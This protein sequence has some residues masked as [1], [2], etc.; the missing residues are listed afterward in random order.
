MVNISYLLFLYVCFNGIGAIPIITGLASQ[1]VDNYDNVLAVPANPRFPGGRPKPEATTF[2]PTEDNDRNDNQTYG[3]GGEEGYEDVVNEKHVLPNTNLCRTEYETIYEIEDVETKEEKCITVSERKCET[4]F[5]SKC[6]PYLENVCQTV[7][8]NKCDTE[9]NQECQQLFREEEESY[10][11]DKCETKTVRKCE[12]YWKMVSNNRKVWEEN[13]DKC[14]D[15]LQTECLPVTN[16]RVNKLPYQECI[17]VPVQKCTQVEDNVCNDV[18][19]ERC[20]QE[21]YEECRNVPREECKIE[22]KLIPQQISRQIQIRV[23]DDNER[24]IGPEYDDYEEDNPKLST[25]THILQP[26]EQPP[27]R[28]FNSNQGRANQT[29]FSLTGSCTS[30]NGKFCTDDDTVDVGRGSGSCNTNLDCPCCAPFCAKS[31]YCQATNVK[32]SSESCPVQKAA[33]FCD[34]SVKSTCWSPGVDDVDCPGHGLCCFDGCANTCHNEQKTQKNDSVGDCS[35]NEYVSDL[36]Y[37]RCEKDFK[38]G[39][40]C[41]VNQLSTCKDL[42]SSSN[43]PGKQYSWEACSSKKFTDNISPRSL[44]PTDVDD[45]YDVKDEFIDIRQDTFPCT[46]IAHVNKYGVGNCKMGEKRFNNENVCYVSLPSSCSDLKNSNTDAG[47][48][49]SAVACETNRKS[50]DLPN[51]IITFGHY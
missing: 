33:R 44:L 5:R 43:D 2:L 9:Y 35:C 51:S 13:P 24:D 10:V 11:E 47:K 20:N 39:P 37:G 21:P 27:V 6:V 41:Y 17:Q 16:V 34:E 48:F 19:R 23:C 38:E 12:K 45:D 18:P 1:V 3:S 28:I 7:L 26:T 29:T 42:V 14:Q 31:G 40:V 49:L 32:S 22:H 8:R 4:T 15:I 25:E 50:N 46:C 30:W 36:G